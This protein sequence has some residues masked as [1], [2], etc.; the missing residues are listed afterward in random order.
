V[1]LVDFDAA[2]LYDG[3]LAERGTL[4]SSSKPPVEGAMEELL[5]RSLLLGGADWAP[6]VSLFAV[7]FFYFRA[8]GDDYAAGGRRYLALAMWLLVGRLVLHVAWTGFVFYHSMS[9]TS[10]GPGTV[11]PFGRPPGLASEDVIQ[12]LFQLLKGVVFIAALMTFV[13]GMMLLPRARDYSGPPG[14]PRITE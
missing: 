1:R 5:L 6:L 13:L 7:A 9:G 2:L 8:P 11:T 14:A 4:P 3:R 12:G 10:S